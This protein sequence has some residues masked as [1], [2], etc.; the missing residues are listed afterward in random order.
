MQ[1]YAD[2]STILKPDNRLSTGQKILLA[3]SAV[4]FAGV[5][6]LLYFPIYH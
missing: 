1:N 4:C 6:A 5:A 2:L 3:F